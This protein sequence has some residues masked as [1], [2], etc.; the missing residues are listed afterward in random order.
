DHHRQLWIINLT[1]KSQG[2]IARLSKS[3]WLDWIIRLNICICKISLIE[4]VAHLKR[5]GKKSVDRMIYL[6]FLLV[7]NCSTC[8]Q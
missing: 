7:C 1:F 4:P 2:L 8:L 6:T 3:K 5:S